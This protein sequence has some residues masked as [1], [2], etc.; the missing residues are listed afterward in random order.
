MEILELQ[1]KHFGKFLEYKVPLHGGVN[2]IGG[3][4]ETG[5]TTLQAFIRAMLYGIDT[6][7]GR[8]GEE[9]FLRRPWD[10]P[11]YFAGAMRVKSGGKIWRIER[12]FSREERSLRVV[13]ESD[14]QI[15]PRPQEEL[16]RMLG[17]MSEQAFLGTVFIPQGGAPVDQA[18]MDELQRY[19][20]NFQEARDG[21]LDVDKAVGFLK[22]R[23]KELE[24]RRKQ[25]QGELGERLAGLDRE[26][27]FLQEEL[28]REDA[29]QPY[30]AEMADDMGM[31][32]ASPRLE[33]TGRLDE[34][35]RR[36]A[37][38]R[39][40]SRYDEKRQETR[41]RPRSSAGFYPVFVRLMAALLGV[42]GVLALACA[43]FAHSIPGR[44]VL[45]MLAAFLLLLCGLTIRSIIADRA[46][47]AEEEEREPNEMRR[48]QDRERLL[49]EEGKKEGARREKEE[50]RRSMMMRLRLLEQE[51]DELW[52]QADRGGQEQEELAALEMAR[53]RILSLSAG[54]AARG[55]SQLAGEASRIL[56]Q[57]SGGRYTRIALDER[58]QLQISTPDM[59]LEPRQ[60]STSAAER[61]CLAV[62]IAAADILSDGEPVPL[63]LD[64]PFA[65]YDDAH[66]AV[67]LRCL[68]ESG[69]QVILFTCSGR[70]QAALGTLQREMDS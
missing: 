26:I 16:D 54:M 29:A 14:G 55:S 35:G 12:S 59:V 60:I 51:R 30:A 62:R 2:I 28:G 25:T 67:A 3:G 43:V 37:G 8:R 7:R 15:S 9:Y 39:T 33:E 38:N 48:M 31:P 23:Q 19:M 1:V 22:A 36:N 11:A 18:L 58:G 6:G 44:I 64:E 45:L 53:E 47:E 61:A 49:L 41:G 10:D 46:M 21:S 63:V 65:M 5:K 50:K 20:V 24:D 34:A 32:G 70:E 69:R 56:A 40:G 27:R 42:G 52:R 17:G 13:S 66:L 57:L 4:N 68:L